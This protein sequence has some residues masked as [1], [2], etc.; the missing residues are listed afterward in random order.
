MRTLGVN[1]NKMMH[2]QSVG[3]QQLTF[4]LE[5]LQG[6]AKL[7]RVFYILYVGDMATTVILPYMKTIKEL[8]VKVS[9]LTLMQITKQ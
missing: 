8:S 9:K 1:I 3:A 4:A 6:L 7:H 2:R 5:Y